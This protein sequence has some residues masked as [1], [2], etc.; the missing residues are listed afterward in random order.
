MKAFKISTVAF[1]QYCRHRPAGLLDWDTDEKLTRIFLLAVAVPTVLLYDITG[2]LIVDSENNWSL[3]C[4][5]CLVMMIPLRV[6]IY[7]IRLYH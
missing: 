2:P 7:F 5:W 1:S 6:R 4:F 3:R